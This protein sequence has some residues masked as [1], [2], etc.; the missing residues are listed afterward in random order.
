MDMKLRK[1][2]RLQDLNMMPFMTQS[3]VRQCAYGHFIPI[4]DAATTPGLMI[5]VA[6]QM[7]CRHANTVIF[8]LHI[9]ERHSVIRRYASDRVLIKSGQ[10][11]V[12]SAG[13]ME[14]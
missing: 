8:I 2:P 13:K 11:S 6:K 14:C 10:W 7:Q 1:V 5:Q 12:V 3:D 4:G 9:P